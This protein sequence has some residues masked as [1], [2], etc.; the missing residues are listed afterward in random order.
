MH[1]DLRESLV[2]KRSFK[3]ESFDVVKMY[4]SKPNRL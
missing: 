3:P 2:I 1:F 4:Q